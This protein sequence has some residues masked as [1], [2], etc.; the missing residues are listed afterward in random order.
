MEEKKVHIPAISCH[1]CKITIER[2]LGGLKAIESVEV[3][4]DSRTALIRWKTPLTWDEIKKTLTEIGY[5]P[6]E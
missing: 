1:H 3:N 5:P 2:E 6:Q 4:V